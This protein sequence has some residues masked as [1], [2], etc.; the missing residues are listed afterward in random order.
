[1]IQIW[2]GIHLGSRSQLHKFLSLRNRLKKPVLVVM[3]YW[4]ICMFDSSMRAGTISGNTWLA[5]ILWEN[6]QNGEIFW[7]YSAGIHFPFGY[8]ILCHEE[9]GWTR[10]DCD[11]S[12]WNIIWFGLAAI[13]VFE[14]SE[15]EGWLVLFGNNQ[16]NLSGVG[17][18]SNFK[19][20][21]WSGTPI[22]CPI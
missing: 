18:S 20:V 16:I 11:M 3:P 15:R 1:M 4:Q 5:M 10:L 8:P 21:P 7:L 13:L 19:T 17:M 12:R 6:V 22:F 2:L 14:K 9:V